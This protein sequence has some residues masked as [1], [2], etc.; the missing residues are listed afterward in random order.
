MDL[1]AL[2]YFVEVVRLQGFTRAA[3]ALHVTQPTI[4][5][6]IRQLEDE[7]G[8]PLLLREGR[9]Q[10]LTD[11]GRIVFERGQTLLGD[12]ERLRRELAE[13]ADLSRGDL[14]LGL[15]PM[16]GATFFAPVLREF[17]LRHSGIA[18]R[19]TGSLVWLFAALSLGLALYG[20]TVL[21]AV[22]SGAWFRRV[23]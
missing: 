9:S 20:L 16:V 14:A 17:G 4:S 18:L 22:M 8:A 19:L 2:R 3:D 13:L 7:V 5:K 1:R 23:L 6:M 21:A 11:A 10:R 12:F 15:P